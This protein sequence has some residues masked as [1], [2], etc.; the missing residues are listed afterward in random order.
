MRPVGLA[1]SDQC[2]DFDFGAQ[3]VAAGLGISDDV[4]MIDA[5]VGAW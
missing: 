5:M 4:V 3:A 2:S 1:C